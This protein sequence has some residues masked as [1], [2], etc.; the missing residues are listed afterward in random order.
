MRYYQIF[1]DA[2]RQFKRRNEEFL[3][4]L[5]DF[6][7]EIWFNEE[8]AVLHNQILHLC[9]I[10]I[11]EPGQELPFLS[12]SI[13]ICVKISLKST[14]A[15]LQDDVHRSVK[16]FE[17]SFIHFLNVEPFLYYIVHIP[18]HE[19]VIPIVIACNTICTIC[20]VVNGLISVALVLLLAN[21]TTASILIE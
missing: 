4:Q 2:K 8:V 18:C 21:A 5:V 16:F 19:T 6:R 3:N 20:N 11:P 10:V 1:T 7:W 17:P 13:R 14:L 12:V 9:V 15:G